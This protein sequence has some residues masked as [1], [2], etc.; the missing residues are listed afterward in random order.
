MDEETKEKEDVSEALL[1]AQHE[2]NCRFA[3]MLTLTL[4]GECG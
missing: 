3:D 1:E 4:K 2:A